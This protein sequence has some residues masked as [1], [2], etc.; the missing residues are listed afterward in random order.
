MDDK[1]VRLSDVQTELMLAVERYTVAH[2]A[3]GMGTVV[4]SE[5]LISVSNALDTVRS[6]PAVDAVDRA[7]YEQVAW[8]RDTALAQ[9][10]DIGKGLGEKMDDVAKVVRCPK[11]VHSDHNGTYCKLDK[12]E[13]HPSYFC[14]RGQRR[15]DGDA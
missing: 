15:E 5:D 12:N 9:L 7:V 6:I 1:L 10:S 11:C 8:E 13:V 4:W 3:H 14:G 2:E